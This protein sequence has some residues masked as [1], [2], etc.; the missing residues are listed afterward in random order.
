MRVE[1]SRVH[2]LPDYIQGVLDIEPDE[3]TV[4]E[5]LASISWVY[6]GRRE[7]IALA[8]RILRR[9]V[10]GDWHPL[11]AISRCKRWFLAEFH[12]SDKLV[13]ELSS[14]TTDY[15]DYIDSVEGYPWHFHEMT[16]KRCGKKFSI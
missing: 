2:E 3:W 6:L 5:M 14:G 15:H 10:F 13:C 16:C 4:P 11:A 12:L 8:L 1:N 7:R 9:A